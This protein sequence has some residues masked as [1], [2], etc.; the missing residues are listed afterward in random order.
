MMSVI[1]YLV[2]YPSYVGA[3]LPSLFSQLSLKTE[4][5][6]DSLRFPMLVQRDSSRYY[7]VLLTG[8]SS[9]NVFLDWY[10]VS[11]LHTR[12]LPGYQS[13]LTYRL[14]QPHIPRVGR[15]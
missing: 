2:V 10:T 3:V 9:A 15:Q 13:L 5:M 4:I 14:D 6:A 7:L 11:D 1:D 8:Q 12:G